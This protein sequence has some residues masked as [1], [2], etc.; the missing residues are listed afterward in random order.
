MTPIQR[1]VRQLL[2][3][4]CLL[5]AC[6]DQ[7]FDPRIP[8][9]PD[10]TSPTP[11]AAPL[12]VII[13]AGDQQTDTVLATLAEPL[14]VMVVTGG[15]PVPDA[16][17]RW[18]DGRSDMI[19]V[20]D[21]SG[22]ASVPWTLHSNAGSQSVRAVVAAGQ[23]N[24][25]AAWFSLTARPGQPAALADPCGAACGLP[26]AQDQLGV[27]G[28]PLAIEYRTYVT[29]AHGNRVDHPIEW[30]VT[31]GGGSIVSESYPGYPESYALHTLGPTAG[32]H[33]ATA[34]VVGVPGAPR[35]TFRA[36]ASLGALVHMDGYPPWF[37]RDSSP[38]RQDS[39]S[40]S[41]GASVG[42]AWATSY[43]WAFEYQPIE[44]DL[45][46][47]D[48][49]TEPASSP[50]RRFGV[51]TRTFEAPGVYRY[52]CNVHSTSF[53]SGHVGIVVVGPG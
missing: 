17:V 30:Q 28:M 52:R 37:P 39:V 32:L 41:V 46:F 34:T 20:T 42:F 7:V 50:R 26:E 23:A 16:W 53:V 22:M 29:D 38:P 14:R 6:S 12:A 43:N 49:P 2:V 40:V 8:P 13:W 11:A 35:I 47:E 18:T 45:L 44:H 33:E 5:A 48:A 19:S 25:A 24:E 36:T 15:T 1:A 9:R 3:L 27:P 4:A 51:H 31:V 10:D 21:A